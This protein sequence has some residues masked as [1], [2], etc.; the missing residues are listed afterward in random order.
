MKIDVVPRDAGATETRRSRR[1]RVHLVATGQKGA[2]TV[3]AYETSGAGEND[4][5]SGGWI[6]RAL[7]LVRFSDFSDNARTAFLT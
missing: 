5:A 7:S 2:Q 3:P 6:Q 1:H 4:T